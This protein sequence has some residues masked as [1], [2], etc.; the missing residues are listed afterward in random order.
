VSAHLLNVV[1]EGGRLRGLLAHGARVAVELG[2]GGLH[3]DLERKQKHTQKVSSFS[4]GACKASAYAR[5]GTC[6]ALRAAHSKVLELPP[7]TSRVSGC[8]PSDTPSNAAKPRVYTFFDTCMPMCY[9]LL[10]PTHLELLDASGCDLK[11]AIPYNNIHK[12]P[13]ALGT[14]QGEP[15]NLDSPWLY[16]YHVKVYTCHSLTLNCP[17]PVNMTSSEAS[18][19]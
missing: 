10:T 13:S 14:M 19:T 6:T 4:V 15:H 3:L 16:T 7:Q 9:W 2:D 1:E 12:V 18:S 17:M 8:A 5:G 11:A